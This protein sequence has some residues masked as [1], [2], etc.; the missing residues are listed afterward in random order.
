[1]AHFPKIRLSGLWR[2]VQLFGELTVKAIQQESLHLGVAEEQELPMERF[3]S[4]TTLTAQNRPGMSW[5]AK[6]KFYWK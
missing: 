6:L 3:R 1:M 5:R 4:Q 2:C